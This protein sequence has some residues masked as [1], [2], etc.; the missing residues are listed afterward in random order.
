MRDSIQRRAGVFQ[1][2]VTLLALA[3]YLPLLTGCLFKPRTPEPPTGAEIVY[4]P[5]GEVPNIL[6]NLETALK[7][8]DIA[9]Y[10]DAIGENFVYLPDSQTKNDYPA[11]DWA[12][13]DREQELAFAGN[14]FDNIS[15]L[16]A[17]L[18]DTDI[19]V[20]I[21]SGT[22]VEW[23]VIY[24][25]EQTSSDGS[26]TKYRGG[27]EIIFRQIGS[28]WYIDSWEDLQGEPDPDTGAALTSMGGLRGAFA[29]K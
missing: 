13:W 15:A 9:G 3:A 27:V 17:N 1:T 29:S 6:A 23:E 7:N 4:L 26:V 11:V 2:V 14:M 8:L 16:Q 24:L 20:D 12:N 10:D 22:E 25:L 5:R 19:R 28:F 18:R 21:G